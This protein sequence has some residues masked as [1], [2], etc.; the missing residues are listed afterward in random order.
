M[1]HPAQ[2]YGIKWGAPASR[3]GLQ[4]YDHVIWKYC[5]TPKGNDYGIVLEKKVRTKNLTY[6]TYYDSYAT[7]L[8]IPRFE[9]RIHHTFVLRQVT[10]VSIESRERLIELINFINRKH[11]MRLNEQVSEKC[12]WLKELNINK[13]KRKIYKLKESDRHADSFTEVVW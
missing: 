7:V 4:Q 10:E 11:R 13:M 2:P 6:V 3:L 5:V 1:R 9:I 12:L 8:W